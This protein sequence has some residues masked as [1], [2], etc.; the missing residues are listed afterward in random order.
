LFNASYPAR[1]HVGVGE[2]IHAFI[3]GALPGADDP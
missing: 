2:V 3:R 1:W